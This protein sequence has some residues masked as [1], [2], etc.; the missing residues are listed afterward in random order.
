VID[1][2]AA[3]RATL[4]GLLR[5]SGHVV[6]EAEGGAAGL[7]RLGAGPVDVVITDLG[8][9][10]VTGWEVAL[11]AKRQSPGL[12]VIL[13]TGWGEETTT[14]GPGAGSVDRILGKPVRLNDLLQA[15][16]DLSA[17]AG[18]NDPPTAYPDAS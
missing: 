2:D 13:L 3:V 8:M 6:S 7:A 10:E 18:A 12:P 16:E 4:V 5:A 17:R 9:P 1:D 14:D 11:A 15:I